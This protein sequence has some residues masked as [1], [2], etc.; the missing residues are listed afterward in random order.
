[1]QP[2]RAIL[3]DGSRLLRDLIKRILETKA[4]FDVVHELDGLDELSSVLNTTK[5]GW[6]FF[7]L[8]HNLEISEEQKIELLVKHPSLRMVLIRVDGNHMDME[9][10]AHGHKD[11]TEMTLDD[12]TLL[13]RKEF[14]AME[15]SRKS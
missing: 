9:W 1:M 13:L 3:V 15:G 7:V 8:S 2:R 4:G 12:I 10:L 11:L 6:T 14:H 5:V